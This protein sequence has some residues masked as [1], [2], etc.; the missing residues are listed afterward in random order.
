ME[1]LVMGLLFFLIALI[2]SSAG[3][4]GGSSYIALMLFMGVAMTELRFIALSCNIIVVAGSTINYMKSGYFPKKKIFYLVMLSVPFAFL[5]GTITLSKEIYIEI[6]AI[7]LLIAAILMMF[8]HSPKDN[9]PSD[10]NPLGVASLGG[11]IGFISGLI[12]IGGGVF[13]APVLYLIKWDNIIKI[14][15][16]TSFFILVNSVAGILGQLL[17]GIEINWHYVVV[18]G[19]AVL[20]GG[21]IGNRLNIHVLKPKYIKFVTALLIGFVGLRILLT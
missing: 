2:Y 8:S 14:G 19:I 10:Y 11:G 9:S 12:G 1:L 21:Q 16:A 17:S 18:L 4:G 3:F 5:G 20:I 7:S 6:A 13:L 15:A